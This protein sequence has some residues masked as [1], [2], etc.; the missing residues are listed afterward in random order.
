[1]EGIEEWSRGA[2]PLSEIEVEST[3]YNISETEQSALLFDLAGD[4][5]VVIM[6]NANL[7]GFVKGVL[8][9]YYS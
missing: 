3:C 9:K 4:A 5:L 6:Q 2:L 7:S 8:G 1:M